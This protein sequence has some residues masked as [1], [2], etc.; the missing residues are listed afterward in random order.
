LHY[1]THSKE[2]LDKADKKLSLIKWHTAR[3]SRQIRRYSTALQLLGTER[4]FISK[5]DSPDKIN[6]DGDQ[7]LHE[8]TERLSWVEASRDIVWST[9]T[10]TH[11]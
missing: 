2:T 8:T 5:R 4:H 9:I 11:I 3:T 7:S 1:D 6:T 10:S